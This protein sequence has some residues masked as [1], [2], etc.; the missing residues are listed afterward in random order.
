MHNSSDMEPT[1]LVA[2][3]GMNEQRSV[4]SHNWDVLATEKNKVT[5]FTGNWIQLERMVSEKSGQ[6]QKDNYN[7]DKYIFFFLWCTHFYVVQ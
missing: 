7:F 6:P 4:H 3:R 5:L 1:Q 2:H